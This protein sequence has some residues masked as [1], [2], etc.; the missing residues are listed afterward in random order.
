MCGGSREEHLAMQHAQPLFDRSNV[1]GLSHH[2]FVQECGFGVAWSA[3]HTNP[4]AEQLTGKRGCEDTIMSTKRA[5]TGHVGAPDG[6]CIDG[7]RVSLGEDVQKGGFWYTG[8]GC[9]Q[10][11]QHQAHA[12]AP[13]S[14]YE[15][16]LQ[17]EHDL[18]VSS[19]QHQH[20]QVESLRCPSA[21]SGTE[22]DVC[23][24]FQL[25]RQSSMDCDHLMSGPGHSGYS[26][27]VFD[28]LPPRGC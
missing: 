7:S 3:V 4:L 10:H 19:S 26:A 9:V 11:S 20:A 21:W 25:P 16:Y 12:L 18:M 14:V 27:M 17:K 28:E 13:K 24:A 8:D 22:W 1:G 2:Y 6:H 5:C 15:Q 23:P